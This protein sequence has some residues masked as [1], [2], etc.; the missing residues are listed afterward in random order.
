MSVSDLIDF[1]D[2]ALLEKAR[3]QE[4]WYFILDPQTG[5]PYVHD[6]MTD[7]FVSPAV[8]EKTIQ[9][10]KLHY[11]KRMIVKEYGPKNRTA[12]FGM[13][14]FA[15]F[16]YLG[17]EKIKVFYDDAFGVLSRADFLPPR[18]YSKLDP[19]SVPVENPSLRLLLNEFLG[20]ARWDKRYEGKIEYLQ[21]KEKELFEQ[22]AKA[23][24]LVPMQ[25]Q[26][27]DEVGFAKTSNNGKNYLPLFTDWLEFSK[28]Y[29]KDIWKGS[30]VSVKEAVSIAGEDDMV[31]NFTCEAMVLTEDVLKR[32]GIL[33]E[34]TDEGALW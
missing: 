24:F 26:G 19:V 5:S 6:G 21:K 1:K 13:N 4:Q 18:D 30:I 31:I 25:Q 8:L 12:T 27:E 29:N 10:D 23:R 32:M 17:L 16:Y 33:E 9:A 28:A 34:K 14:I 11:Q 7:L 2:R 22:I 3:K 15:Y 20:E